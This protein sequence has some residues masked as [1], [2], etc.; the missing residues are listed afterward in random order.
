MPC[1]TTLN[2]SPD[3]RVGMPQGRTGTVL[4]GVASQR[5]LSSIERLLDADGT[6]Q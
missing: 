3:G 2:A 6:G 5:S 1:C 4:G